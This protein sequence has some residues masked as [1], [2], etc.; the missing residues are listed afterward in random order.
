MIKLPGT[1]EGIPA[2]RELTADGINVNIT[3]LFSRTMYERVV[4]AY[5]AGLEDR[6]PGG[7]GL[8]CLA[9]VASF[10][11]SRIDSAVDPRVV[12]VSRLARSSAPTR[13][14]AATR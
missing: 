9:S 14:A 4:D 8:G 3:L 1:E 10:F 11:V 5:L 13:W 6:L 12:P 2:I 7:G